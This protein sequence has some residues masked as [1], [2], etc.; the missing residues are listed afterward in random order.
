MAGSRTPW[1]ELYIYVK[2][3]EPTKIPKKKPTPIP[4]EKSKR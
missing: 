3:T 1:L 2:I 4:I